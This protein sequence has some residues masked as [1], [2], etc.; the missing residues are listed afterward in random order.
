DYKI[1]VTVKQG[2][3][4]TDAES[5]VVHDVVNTR[6][7][8]P[9]ATIS[10][11]SNPLVALYSA[12]PLSGDASPG[13]LMHVE[14][15][16]A[17]PN[18]SWQSTN[19]LPVEEGKSTNFLVAGLLPGKTYETRD[20]LEDGTASAPLTFIAGSPPSNLSFPTF[21]AIQPPGPGPD[22]NQ[23]MIFHQLPAS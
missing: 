14:F 18:P 13:E 3:A 12:Q 19:A 4:A 23:D 6:I 8:G 9:G 16:L 7:T 20:V 10:E 15:S 2:F 11:T 22:Q 5:A 17:G 21:T 1:K